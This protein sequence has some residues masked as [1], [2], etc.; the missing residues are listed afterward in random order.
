M[1]EV[2][3]VWEFLG[4]IFILF[5]LVNGSYA[6]EEA[7]DTDP[8]SKDTTNNVQTFEWVLIVPV[9]AGYLLFLCWL[10]RFFDKMN[11]CFV[12]SILIALTLALFFLDRVSMKIRYVL[13]ALTIFI[14]FAITAY[15]VLLKPK[16]EGEGTLIRN[17]HDIIRNFIIISVVLLWPGILF[18]FYH[19]KVEYVTFYGIENLK[20]PV[21][22]IA[23]AS[24]GILSYLLLSIEE[25]FGQLIPEYKKISIAW[26]Y[27]R[28]IL[29]AP[30]IALVGFYTLYFRELEGI[31]EIN[32]NFVFIFSFFAGAFTKTVEEWIYVWVQK[33]LP[34]DRKD[35]F[36]KRGV[37]KIEESDFV[38]KLGLDD[39]LAYMLYG[40]KIRTIEE[41]AN[42]EA[43]QLID[44]LNIDTRNLGE[45]VV[46]PLKKQGERFGSYSIDQIR[47]SISRA[48]AY[49]DMDKS[50]LVTMLK[51]DRDQAYKLHYFANIKTIQ[52]LANCDPKDVHDKLCDCKKEA[53]ELAKRENYEY[54][55]AHEILCEYSERKIEEFKEKAEKEWELKQM[56]NN[57]PEKGEKKIL[58]DEDLIKCINVVLDA[59][60]DS[61]VTKG[62]LMEKIGTKFGV[63][64]VDEIITKCKELIENISPDEQNEKIKYEELDLEK[65]KVIL[66][67]YLC[68]KK[69]KDKWGVEHL[70]K[71]IEDIIKTLE[72]A[73]SNARNVNK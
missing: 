56:E 65:I 25:T 52:D 16:K 49:Q 42:S 1:G 50:E 6:A 47:L 39:D 18:Y 28:R 38:K 71:D 68:E 66:N 11:F 48:K 60:K 58:S 7:N 29:I 40:A 21:Y 23:A 34:A 14:I 19:H 63:E 73:G 57:D 9:A 41:L 2:K 10:C 64:D 69:I 12:V 61:N 70:E 27:I 55:K 4:L 22:I 30:F 36:D 51:L 46:C 33:L 26:S 31:E 24:I 32:D 35:E 3:G 62:Y 37:Y 44:K 67:C 54:E 53:E 15:E 5:L 17:L 13:I 43:E 20:F 59:L 45:G 72:Q 8:G